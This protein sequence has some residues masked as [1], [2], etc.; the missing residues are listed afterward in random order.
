MTG[1]LMMVDL[2]AK[3]LSVGDFHQ[4]GLI[5]TLHRIGR[6]DVEHLERELLRHVANRPI[7]LVL[8]CLYSELEGQA[9]H[10]IVKELQKV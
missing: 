6:V 1:V 8:P 2:R 7:A 4:V 9:V 10:T 3:L 5:S